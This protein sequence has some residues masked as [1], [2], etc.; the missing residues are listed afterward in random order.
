MGGA[1]GSSSTTFQRIERPLG[2][3]MRA[4]FTSSFWG[5]LYEAASMFRTEGKG[6]E[7]R[8]GNESPFWGRKET[9]VGVMYLKEWN[10]PNV[11]SAWVYYLLRVSV[12]GT[13]RG[14]RRDTFCFHLSMLRLFK[15]FF[16]VFFFLLSCVLMLVLH[17]PK[18]KM[19]VMIKKKKWKDI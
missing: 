5:M 10:E 12:T 8:G 17:M 6:L 7:G 9:W 19:S 3:L 16:T 15:L 1:D 13:P 14:D 11:F 2:F 18:W 4:R